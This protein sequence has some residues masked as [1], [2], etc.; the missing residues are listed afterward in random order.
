[1]QTRSRYKAILLYTEEKAHMDALEIIKKNYK[2][3]SIV[4]NRD[5]NE[6]GEL[7]KEHMHIILKLDNTC[8]NSTIENNLGLRAG[9]VQSVISLKGA[10]E[11]LI[12]YNNPDKFQY[13]I[14]EVEGDLRQLLE[15]YLN[16]NTNEAQRFKETLEIVKC[17]RPVSVFDLAVLLTELGYY[18]ILKK[19]S[20]LLI[21]LLKSIDK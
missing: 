14:T 20:Y 9:L 13:S 5:T 6:D 12:H 4:H 21:N 17:Y 19:N 1:M 15:N 2:Y 11:Y 18:D 10:L 7:K 16:D 8:E 3:A